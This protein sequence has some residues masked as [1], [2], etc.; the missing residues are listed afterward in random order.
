[1]GFRHERL[2]FLIGFN[3]H[4]YLIQ[5]FVVL[6]IVIPGIPWTVG[7]SCCQ[8]VERR[9]DLMVRRRSHVTKHHDGQEYRKGRQ[10]EELDQTDHVSPHLREWIMS[11]D[12]PGLTRT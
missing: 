9:R 1:M 11:R 12:R 5:M 10:E 3:H 6:S 8:G 4:L 2:K 7:D